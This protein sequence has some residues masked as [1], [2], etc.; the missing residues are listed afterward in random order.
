MF[1]QFPQG[2]DAAEP[3]QVIKR[4]VIEIYDISATDWR[5]EFVRLC[6]QERI[7]KTQY[8]TWYR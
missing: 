5:A 2:P 8:G 3:I 1:R 7:F 6:D 4:R